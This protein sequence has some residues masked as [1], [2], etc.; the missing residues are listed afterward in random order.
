[1]IRVA[2]IDDHPVVLAGLRSV[3][4]GTVDM[5]VV[6]EARTTADAIGMLQAQA[7]IDVAIVDVRLAA[8]SG[9]RLMEQLGI[10]PPPWIVLTSWDLPQYVAAALDLGA[11]GFVV[12]DSAPDVLINAVRLVANG[13]TAFESRHLA[14]AREIGRRTLTERER[15]VVQGLIAGRS[16]DE[17]GLDLGLKK[18]TVEAYLTRVYQRFGVSSRTEL[19]ILAEREGWP[20]G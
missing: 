2:I 14:A 7:A 17:I 8:E 11:A 10:D 3:L 16:N 5:V 15:Q 1:M 20:F 13:K 4:D 12:K 19:A 6:G 18:K 9:L